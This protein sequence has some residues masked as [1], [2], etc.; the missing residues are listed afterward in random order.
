MKLKSIVLFG[1]LALTGLVTP[2]QAATRMV[3]C[4]EYYMAT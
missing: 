1:F 4:E 2:M 3:M